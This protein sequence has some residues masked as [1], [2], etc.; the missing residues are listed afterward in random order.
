VLQLDIYKNPLECTVSHSL[1]PTRFVAPWILCRICKSFET[2]KPNPI[3]CTLLCSCIVSNRIT[4]VIQ[5]FLLN[6]P[7]LP[8]KRWV[9]VQQCN[10]NNCFS[11]PFKICV[12]TV[13]WCFNC[14]FLFFQIS[15]I[16]DCI[17]KNFFWVVNFLYVTSTI[18]PRDGFIIANAATQ[19]KICFVKSNRTKDV[20]KLRFVICQCNFVTIC[21]SDQN[22]LEI[23]ILLISST[24]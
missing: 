3:C 22:H 14:C 17:F 13:T 9:S 10:R 8:Q 16:T 20:R 15:E 7:V 24:V 12:S 18:D 4:C 21:K 23:T 1:T 11:L 5:N 6:Y 19:L 2:I